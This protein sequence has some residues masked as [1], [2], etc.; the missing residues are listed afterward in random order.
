MDHLG[1]GGVVEGEI[2]LVMLRGN[3][4]HKHFCLEISQERGNL[5]NLDVNA[6]IIHMFKVIIT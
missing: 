4:P 2:D 6:I 1:Y 3:Q 5:C